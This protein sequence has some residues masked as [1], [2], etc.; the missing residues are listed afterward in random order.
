MRAAERYKWPGIDRT[1]LG[2]MVANFDRTHYVFPD[3][4]EACGEPRGDMK[5]STCCYVTQ[6][7]VAEHEGEPTLMALLDGPEE[8]M[9]DALSYAY[10]PAAKHHVDG[11]GVGACIDS[12]YFAA[13]APSPP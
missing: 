10:V 12:I 4:Q 2:E 3:V 13:V 9:N 6:V 7:K 5:P 11:K 8:R 1:T